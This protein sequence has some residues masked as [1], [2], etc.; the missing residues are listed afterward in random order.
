MAALLLTTLASLIEAVSKLSSE[1]AGQKAEPNLDQFLAL[2]VFLLVTNALTILLF[3]ESS[4][5]FVTRLVLRNGDLALV[6][7]G[8]RSVSLDL[9][10]SVRIVVANSCNSSVEF[11]F[12]ANTPDGGE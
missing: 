1:L 9:G 8:D 4:T 5:F 6:F 12:I 10:F 7:S 3:M 11:R 2:I